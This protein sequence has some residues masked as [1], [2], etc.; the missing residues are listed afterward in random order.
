[1]LS[2]TSVRAGFGTCGGPVRFPFVDALPVGP[3]AR[4]IRKTPCLL[5][6]SLSGGSPIGV[7]G[8]GLRGRGGV[9]GRCRGFV[10]TGGLYERG[11][12]KSRGGGL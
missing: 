10:R 1:M 11:G 6:G 7:T 12:V 8:G 2:S 9:C 3:A 4:V 5:W